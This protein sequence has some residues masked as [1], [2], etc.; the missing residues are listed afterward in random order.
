[1]KGIFIGIIFLYS[2]L[3]IQ[4]QDTLTLQGCYN[5]AYAANPLLKNKEYY[6]KVNKL[7]NKIINTNWYP[8]TELNGQISY[9][10]DIVQMDIDLSPLVNYINGLI[11]AGM[12]NPNN[13]LPSLNVPEAPKDQYK[14]TLDIKQTLYDGGISKKNKNLEEK[15]LLVN[16]QQVEV[17]LFSVK[18]QVNQ[19]FFTITVLKNNIELLEVLNQNIDTNI[20]IME[21]GRRNGTVMQSNIDVLNAERLKLEQQLNELIISR[22]AAVKVLELLINEPLSYECTLQLPV[23]LFSDSISNQRPELLLF[24]YNKEMLDISKDLKKSQ[25]FPKAFAFTQIGYGNPGLNMLNNEFDT[26]YIIG[27]GFKWNI[28]DWNKNKNERQIIEIQKNIMDASKENFDKN[29]SMAAENKYAEIEKLDKMLETDKEIIEIRQRITESALSQLKNGVINS[30]QYLV[31][32]NAEKQ[33]KINYEIHKIR[34]IQEKV[35][36]LNLYGNI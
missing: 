10:S 36:Y 17:D 31:E 3:L 8:T 22:N 23:V 2:G 15:L 11:P 25:L 19:L 33:A 32:F 26:Y 34:L 24:D 18:E 5:K 14:V 20:S 35:N 16:N 21:S 28:Y 9:Q 13:A 1:M 12:G 29:I 27:A 4:A 7:K 30:S 6:A